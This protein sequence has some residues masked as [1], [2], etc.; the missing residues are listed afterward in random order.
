MHTPELDF[1]VIGLP[2]SGTTWIANWLTTDRSL[3]LHDPFA[4]AMPEAWE[5]DRRKFGIS[6]TLSYLLDGWL[7]RFDCPVAIID[8]N[9]EACDASLQAMGFS[10]T[11]V[12]Q[13]AFSQ[14]KGRVFSF[15]DLWLEPSARAL[16]S[17]VLP[18]E[19]FDVLRYRQLVR[20][21]VQPHPIHWTMNLTVLDEIQRI[22]LLK[23]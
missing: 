13:H 9:T 3:C 6:C 22:G 1:I 7:D 17:Y 14:A 2:R 15:D 20:T 8:R 12:L 4:I 18:G 5:R 19:P 23:R 21:Q 10:D 11:K 16:W